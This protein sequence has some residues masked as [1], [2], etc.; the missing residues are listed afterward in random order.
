MFRDTVDDINKKKS[1][2]KSDWIDT[3]NNIKKSWK[4][5]KNN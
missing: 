3:K 1:F 4:Y 2:S 5:I